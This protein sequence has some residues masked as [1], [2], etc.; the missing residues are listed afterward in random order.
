[1]FDYEIILLP[2]MIHVNPLFKINGQDG[3]FALL[4]SF[5]PFPS[6]YKVANARYVYVFILVRRVM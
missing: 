3:Y 2:F 1:M 6:R 5:S 4:K